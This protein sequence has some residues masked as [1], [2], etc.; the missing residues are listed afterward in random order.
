MKTLTRTM[1]RAIRSASTNGSKPRGKLIRYPGGFWYPDGPGQHSYSTATVQAL[2]RRGL[3][4]YTQWKDGR[5]GRF[6][7]EMTLTIPDNELPGLNLNEF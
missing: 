1:K 4:E 6:P 5:N 2:V 3:A 7:I